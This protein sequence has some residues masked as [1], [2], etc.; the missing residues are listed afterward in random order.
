MI[1]VNWLIESADRE[2]PSDQLVH[3]KLSVWSLSFCLFVF[4]SFHKVLKEAAALVMN[5]NWLI[6]SAVE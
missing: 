1:N 3:I 4:L 6:E 5:V 2:A